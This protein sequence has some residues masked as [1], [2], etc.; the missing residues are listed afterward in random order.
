MDQ[1]ER[2]GGG[3][4]TTTRT[5]DLQTTFLLFVI[6]FSQ[7]HPMEICQQLVYLVWHILLLG[8]CYKR[9]MK[10]KHQVCSALREE[11]EEEHRKRMEA[12]NSKFK[13]LT[14]TDEPSRKVWSF[15]H[16]SRTLE[17]STNMLKS[18]S[19]EE[20]YEPLRKIWQENDPHGSNR[21]EVELEM[22]RCCSAD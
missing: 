3:K 22:K 19:L 8:G 7:T 5:G 9:L 6:C 2:R 16:Y 12:V 4:V 20:R 17:K 14:I 1:D 15:I 11:L 10:I 21:D 13:P 18:M